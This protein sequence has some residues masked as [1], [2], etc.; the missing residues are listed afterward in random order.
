MRPNLILLI[1]LVFIVTGITGCQPSSDVEKAP[2][3]EAKESASPPETVVGDG[4]D[5]AATTVED[6]DESEPE[7]KV[8]EKPKET[9]KAK[10]GKGKKKATK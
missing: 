2:S 9:K 7:T 4:D 1:A 3:P 6:S 5:S 10:K 8:E